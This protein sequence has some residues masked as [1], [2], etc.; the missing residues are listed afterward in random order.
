MSQSQ[1]GYREDAM[2]R[3]I[4]SLPYMRYVVDS[5][6]YTPRSGVQKILK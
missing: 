1:S 6:R 5:S 4:E 3:Y 2:R